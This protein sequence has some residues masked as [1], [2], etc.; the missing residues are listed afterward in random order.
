LFAYYT[1]PAECLFSVE[2]LCQTEEGQQTVFELQQHMSS[3]KEMFTD[4]RLA[5]AVV[6]AIDEAVSKVSKFI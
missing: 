1:T 6:E 2:E 3:A 5:R 4:Q